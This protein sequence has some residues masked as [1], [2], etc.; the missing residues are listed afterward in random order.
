MIAKLEPAS[1]GP[2]CGA[3]GWVDADNRRGE[4]N[5]GIRTFWLAAGR[6]HFGTGGGITWDSTPEGEWEETE[7]KARR[8]S[9]GGVF[10]TAA[11]KVWIDGAIVDAA[12]ARISPFDHGLLTGDGVFETL[13]I[14]GGTPFAMRRHLDRLARSASG[15]GLR[16]PDGRPARR[17]DRDRSRQRPGRRP[18]PAHAHRR[19]RAAGLGPRRR[20]SHCGDRGDRD[21]PLAGDDRG[22]RGALAPER[23]RRDRPA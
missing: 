23:A 13:R 7:L 15:L 4:L 19:R 17:D 2:Y 16:V 1:R 10:V 12:E 9:G 18:T 20:G 14:Y 11:A 6:I 22:G 5:V 21:G 8:L 3:I